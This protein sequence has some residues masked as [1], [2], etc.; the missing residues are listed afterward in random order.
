MSSWRRLVVGD[1]APAVLGLD[2]LRLLLVVLP[3]SRASSAPGVA[4][5]TPIVTPAFVAKWNPMFFVAVERPGD[6]DLVV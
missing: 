1:D 5:V 6:V 4:S 2:L 3:G